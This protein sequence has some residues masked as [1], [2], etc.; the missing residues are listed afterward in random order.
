MVLIKR[1][2]PRIIVDA[3]ACPVKQEIIAC[4]SRF[5]V[6]VMMV[7]SYAHRIAPT[8]GVQIIQVDASDQAA[9]LYIAN[10]MMRGDIIITQ[11]FGVA[12]LALAK[13]AIALS[14]R[15]QQYTE[16]NIDYL[17]A[18]RHERSRARRGGARTK[19]PRAMTAQDREIFLHHLTKVLQDQQ[20]NRSC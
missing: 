3:D 20:E 2:K 13:G 4:A 6:Q 12:A 15:G 9:D 16:D 11:D 14:F 10:H 18:S 19:G 17:L 8:E 1:R 7:A 5:G